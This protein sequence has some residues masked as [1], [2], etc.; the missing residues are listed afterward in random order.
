[1][2]SPAINRLEQRFIV[3]EDTA[4]AIRDYV[5]GHL[6]LD[7]HGEAKDNFSYEVH[8]LYLDSRDLQL[9][10]NT[11]NEDENQLK[12]RLR[13]YA[14][15]AEPSA[16]IETKQRVKD[17]YV[18]ERIP[19]QGDIA[20]D[21]L[22]R[23]EPNSDSLISNTRN[24]LLALDRFYKIARDFELKPKLH[25]AFSREAYR[26]DNASLNLDRF[27]RAEPHL[28]TDLRPEM[29]HPT[30]LWGSDVV[31]EMKFI[32]N[33]PEFF[34]QIVRQFAVRPCD[35]EKYVDAVALIGERRLRN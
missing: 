16:F 1:M 21:I 5:R 15:I 30:L 17:R 4:V 9:Y 6:K 19:F 25:V 23:L 29:Q 34:R 35:V 32:K 14:D 26:T 24:D 20:E 8:S 33:E 13:F 28:S 22:S 2:P 3:P 27:V 7:E 10:W 12:V 11:I 18:K 31:L